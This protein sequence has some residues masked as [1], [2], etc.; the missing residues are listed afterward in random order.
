MD[1]ELGLLMRR[2]RR[3]E[4]FD[5]ALLV[6]VADHGYSFELNV[7]GRRQVRET[8]IDEIANVPFFVKAPGQTEGVVDDSLVRNIDVVP[9]IADLLGFKVWWRNDGYSAFSETTRARGQVAMSRRDFSRVISIDRDDLE[10]MREGRRQWRAAKFSTGA[11]SL[12]EFGD[13]WAAAYRIGPHREL[14]GERVAGRP[15]GRPSSVGGVVANAALLGDVDPAAQILPT[16][17][18]GRLTGSPPDVLRDLAVAVNGRIRAVGRS[19]RLRGRQTEYFSML[20]PET[21]LRPGRNRVELFE[22][23]PR[24]AADGCSRTSRARAGSASRSGRGRSP[25]VVCSCR[26]RST[27]SARGRRARCRCG[28]SPRRGGR[29]WRSPRFRISSWSPLRW[30]KACRARAASS[31]ASVSAITV[32]RAA[33]PAAS[34]P[35]MLA[36]SS[37]VPMRSESTSS[38]A[39]AGAPASAAGRRFHMRRASQGLTAPTR[40]RLPNVA[41]RM[42]G[43]RSTPVPIGGSL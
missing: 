30:T 5:K 19:F 7:P 40:I 17:V 4:L 41:R 28:S 1:R 23:R 20:V 9:T 33:S 26:G 21:A 42:A 24:R 18:T 10:R 11:K 25:S 2:L 16:R 29:R 37:P 15:V 32:G 35:K 14:L 13:P 22:V 8:N 36:T 31:L 12:A 43:I 27:R 38:C 39:L 6:V 3:T 34:T